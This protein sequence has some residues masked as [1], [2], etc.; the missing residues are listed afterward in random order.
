MKIH[1]D[2]PEN[3]ECLRY[4]VAICKDVGHK[5]DHYQQSLAKLERAAAARSRWWIS[6]RYF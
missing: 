1:S 6:R 3:L 4:L 2:Y 5:Y